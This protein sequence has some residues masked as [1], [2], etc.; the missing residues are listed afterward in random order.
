MA[1]CST[2]C[3]T[4]H[5]ITAVLTRLTLALHG[6]S[7]MMAASGAT[8]LSLEALMFEFGRYWMPWALA[9]AGYDKVH[10]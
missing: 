5:S 7:I 1:A 2:T 10:C 3:T 9:Q 4:C 8:G 6:R